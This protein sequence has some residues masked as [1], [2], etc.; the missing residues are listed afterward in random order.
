[1]P[2][3]FNDMTYVGVRTNLAYLAQPRAGRAR[4]RMLHAFEQWL[5]H[6]LPDEW[7]EEEGVWN[8][9]WGGKMNWE[10]E[11]LAR[12][13]GLSLRGRA[14]L[15]ASFLFAIILNAAPMAS[16]FTWCAVGP[17][18][19][20]LVQFRQEASKFIKPR[21]SNDHLLNGSQEPISDHELEV[22][23]AEL[24]SNVFM[25]ALWKEAARVGTAAAPA[26]VVME[27]T[28][29]EGFV[30]RRGSVVLMP[31]ALLHYSALFPNGDQ[32]D[33]ERWM[34]D[35]PDLQKRQRSIRTFGG[36][37]GMCSGR[38]AAEQE[39][40]GTVSKLLM[41]FDIEFDDQWVENFQFNPRSLGI[42]HPAGRLTVRLRRR[43]S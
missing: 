36:G 19:E 20:R 42:K 31:T 25:Q 7:P 8:E 30:L 27:D 33:P 29:L 37:M 13:F 34:P 22:D 6:D 35:D 12:H 21:S 26:R 16:W 18:G 9:T 2:Q 28:E 11:H 24:K 17:R 14:C 4:E 38:Y 23:A 1:M 32:V 43:I 39:V 15:Q 40:I 5:Q 10:R 41:L 3:R